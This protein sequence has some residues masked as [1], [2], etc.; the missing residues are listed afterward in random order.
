MLIKNYK[1]EVNIQMSEQ[2]RLWFDAVFCNVWS[3]SAL[4]NYKFKNGFQA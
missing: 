2:W 1:K 3:E 4:F